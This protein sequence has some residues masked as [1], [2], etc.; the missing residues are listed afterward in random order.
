MKKLMLVAAVACSAIALNAAQFTWKSNYSYVVD[1]SG[2]AIT[3]TAGY[4][5]LMN[6]GSIV[7]VLLDSEALYS[8]I[9]KMT[10]LTGTSGDTAAFKTSGS[11]AQKY[12]TSSTF[13]FS[14]S[15]SPL[16]DGSKVGVMY[17]DSS[18]ALSQLVYWDT[19]N[20]K[21]GAKIDAVYTVSGMSAADPADTWSGATFTFAEGTSTAKTY[22][23]TSVPEPTSGLLLL[24]GMAGL[25]LKRKRA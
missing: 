17:K 16:T 21:E 7:L 25:A 9:S 24:L 2:N 1:N 4:N 5:S 22:F 12:G 3:T 19:A 15:E 18:G 13:G 14:V 11:G 23:T 6:G 20:N 8:D 10:V